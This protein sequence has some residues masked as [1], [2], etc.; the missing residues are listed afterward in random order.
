ML[1]TKRLILK[2]Y[3]DEDEDRMIELLTNDT[4]K[5]TYII[6]D[7]ASREEACA[8]FRK[9]KQYSESDGHYEFGIYLSNELI[10]FVNDVSVVH[11][12]IEIGYAFH[13]DFHNKGYATEMLA[14]V[15]EDLF[16]KGF[17]KVVAGAFENNAASFRVMEKCGMWRN[18]KEKAIYYQDRIQRCIYYEVS[19]MTFL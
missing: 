10:G 5:E 7:F 15:I 2:P 12:T 1:E 8:M 17:S 9:L 18:G 4:I 13:P 16:R 3:G 11:E 14:A 19:M 6:P